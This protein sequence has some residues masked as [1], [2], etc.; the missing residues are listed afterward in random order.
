MIQYRELFDD[1][2]Y[3]AP[4]EARRTE[5]DFLLRRGNAFLAI[6]AKATRRLAGDALRGLR[7][8][9]ALEGVSRRVLIYLGAS[10]LRTDDGIDILPLAAF[11]DQLQRCRL[12]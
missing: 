1:V 4:G 10:E 11:L 2:F 7:A 8:I 5:V 12:W 3:W 9:E 6:E